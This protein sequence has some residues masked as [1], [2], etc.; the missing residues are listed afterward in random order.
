MTVWLMGYDGTWAEGKTPT[1]DTEAVVNTFANHKRFYE[2]AFPQ[3]ATASDYRQMLADG[4]VAMNTDNNALPPVFFGLNPDAEKYINSAPLPWPNR[5][6]AAFMSYSTIYSGSEK[7]DAAKAFLEWFFDPENFVNFNQRSKDPPLI[8][9]ADTEEYRK[10]LPWMTGFFTT[11]GVPFPV[12][13]GDY[14]D[15]QPEVQDIVARHASEMVVGA[16]S[17]EDAARQAQKEMD[18]LADTL[19]G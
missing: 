4:K 17:P 16:I 15:N 8:P 18:E 6:G 3:G 9:Q 1:L 7:K 14:R 2:D 11:D 12:P 19:F 13:L 10:S 5:K